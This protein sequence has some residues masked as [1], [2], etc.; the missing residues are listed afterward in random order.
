MSYT[1][2]SVAE[3]DKTINRIRLLFSI[4]VEARASLDVVGVELGFGAGC[5]LLFA[6]G[7]DRAGQGRVTKSIQV[8]G[9]IGCLSLSVPLG[10]VKGGVS[11]VPARRDES[12]IQFG[13]ERWVSEVFTLVRLNEPVGHI[14]SA[15]GESGD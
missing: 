4:E 1:G 9:L 15:S 7:R 14:S 10:V 6:A 13:T 12:V 8:V 3:G 11:F 5:C 2:V